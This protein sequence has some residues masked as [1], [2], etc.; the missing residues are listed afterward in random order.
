MCILFVS[1]VLKVVRHVAQ[2]RAAVELLVLHE[3][4]ASILKCR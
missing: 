4:A 2:V 1:L 3:V